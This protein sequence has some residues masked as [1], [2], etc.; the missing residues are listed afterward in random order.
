MHPG[1]KDYTQRVTAWSILLDDEMFGLVEVFLREL[2]PSQIERGRRLVEPGSSANELIKAGGRPEDETDDQQ[3]RVR[4]EPAIQQPTD[5]QAPDHGR[6]ERDGRAIG[7]ARLDV[8]LF[9]VVI[10]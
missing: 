10:R 4:A 5:D 6:E 8:G 9:F 2:R 1:S 3:P 7:K